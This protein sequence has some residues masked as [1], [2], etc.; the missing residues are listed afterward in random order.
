MV[1]RA[2]SL[3]VGG[4]PPADA[5]AAAGFCDQ[6]HMHRCFVRQFGVTPSEFVRRNGV[7]DARRLDL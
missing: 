7:Q 4:T 3:L 6:S 5:A 2:A 1:R